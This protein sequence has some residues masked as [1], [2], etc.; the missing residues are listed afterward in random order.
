MGG[1]NRTISNDRGSPIAGRQAWSGSSEGFITTMVDLPVIQIPGKLRWRMASDTNGSNEGWR[2]D[3]VDITW[4][5]GDGHTVSDAIADANAADANPL[6]Y[7]HRDSECYTDGNAYPQRNANG[8]AHSQS[9][10]AT[11]S[12]AGASADAAM[13]E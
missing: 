12:D 4:C 2:V 10:A 1:Y 6:G 9:D 11:S 3:T 8:H 5:Q 7:T 13:R